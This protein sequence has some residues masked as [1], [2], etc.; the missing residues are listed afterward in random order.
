VSIRSKLRPC[1][2]FRYEI[3]ACERAIHAYDWQQLVRSAACKGFLVQQPGG[4]LSVYRPMEK[5]YLVRIC[6]AALPGHRSA[7]EGSLELPYEAAEYLCRALECVE[8]A[9]PQHNEDTACAN[10]RDPEEIPARIPA[11]GGS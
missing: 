10:C 3:F 6:F 1:F 4:A 11:A 2:E 7:V 8:D 9:L 5:P